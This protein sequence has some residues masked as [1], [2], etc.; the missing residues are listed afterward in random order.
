MLNA[1]NPLSIQQYPAIKYTGKPVTYDWSNVDQLLQ[2][3]LPNKA[4][5]EIKRIQERAISEKNVSE[6]WRTMQE[7]SVLADE[8]MLEEDSRQEI[9]WDYSERADDLPF[10]LN[11]ITHLYLRNWFNY[12][13]L[14]ENEESK[15]WKL[16]EK[17]VILTEENRADFVEYHDKASLNQAQ[18]L[19]E[20]DSEYTFY[21][22][23][24]DSE[25]ETDPRPELVKQFP[26]LFDYLALT[27]ISNHQSDF[28]SYY[29]NM[30]E[31]IP[32]KDS[33]SFAPTEALPT[34]SDYMRKD[35]WVFPL[36]H[37]I[38]MLHWTQNRLTP[39]SHALEYRIQ[40][41]SQYYQ[42]ENGENLAQ[43]AWKAAEERLLAK[44][45]SSA[46]IFTL[47]IAYE[48]MI[49]GKSYHWKNNSKPTD[50]LS[51]ALQKIDG[52]LKLFPDSEVADGLKD[53]KKSILDDE[54]AFNIKTDLSLNESQ[55]MGVD[56]RN[57]NH[58]TM[59]VFH[60][61]KDPEVYTQNYLKSLT[62]EKVYT[63]Q[64]TFDED[65]RMLP[66]SKDFLLPAFTSTGTYLVLIAPDVEKIEAVLLA[67]TLFKQTDFAYKVVQVTE[68]SVK[69]SNESSRNRIQV[70]NKQT[71]KPI[72]GAKVRYT[73]KVYGM[74]NEHTL[75]LK[76]TT[77]NSAGISEADFTS[78]F[79]YTVSYKG[80]SVS[81]RLYRYSYGQE[82]IKTKMMVYTDRS[83][84]RPGQ[85][86]NYKVIAYDDNDTRKGVVPDFQVRMVATDQNGQ[87]LASESK[88]T[89]QH[90]SIAGS[91]QL[92][93]SG[94]LPGAVYLTINE[95]GAYQYITVEEYKRPTFETVFD[96]FKTQYALGDS[97]T[98]SGKAIS[99]AGYP[100]TN[101]KVTVT[102]SEQRYLPWN[103]K[104]MLKEYDEQEFTT[105]TDE[106]GN[107]SVRF[108]TEKGDDIY[109]VNF[110][111]SA[112]VVNPTGETHEA[113]T[114]LYI[115]KNRFTISTDIQ[116][117]LLSSDENKAGIYV[118]NSEG[119]E[120]EEVQVNYTIEKEIHNAYYQKSAEESEFKAFTGNEL[121][122]A[123]P[124]LKYY[125]ADKTILRV[126]ITKGQ[127]KSGEQIDINK[128]VNSQPG[129]YRL[130]AEAT[131]ETG[132]KVSTSSVFTVINPKSKKNQHQAAF[133]AMTSN[134]S[135]QKGDKIAITI[136]SSF[137]D[138]MAYVE[139]VDKNGIV[140][141]KWV[142]VSQRKVLSIP[143]PAGAKD[144][145][146]I[147]VTANYKHQ[148]Y[149]QSFQINLPD[150][151]ANLI[152]K[153]ETKRDYL[154]PG[155]KETWSVTVTDEEKSAVPSELL[156][157]M[158]DA[159]LD[160]FTNHYWNAQL[161]YPEY[162][163]VNWSSRYEAPVLSENNQWTQYN[164]Y[165]YRW[166]YGGRY[167][168]SVMRGGTWKDT[169]MFESQ[170][171]S[172]SPP[173]PPVGGVFSM[174]ANV[175]TVSGNAEY[176][177]SDALTGKDAEGKREGSAPARIRSNFSETAF[178]FP[179]LVPESDG[180]YR[181][182]FTVPDAL[183]RWRFMSMAH[184]K[185]LQT[186]YSEELFMARKELM[187]T[188]NVPR[189]FRE[190]DVVEFAAKVSN[191]TDASVN[192]TTRLRFI[193][194]YTE[195]D[196][197]DQFGT[198]API[199][200]SINGKS[201]A[202]VSWKLT[203][204]KGTLNMVAY[205]IET[206]SSTYSDAEKRAVPVL[207]SRVLLTESKPFTKTSAGEST[208]TL[209]KVS[210]LGAGTEKV[211]L[212]LEI[213][214]QPLWT[215]LMSLPYLME[216]PHECAEQVFARYFANALA[217]KILQE[218][219]EFRQI[220]ELWKQD[221]PKAF[222]AQLEQNPELKAIILA[223]TPWVMDA[224]NEAQQRA[225]LT[226]LFDE[227]QLTAAI[228][229][230]L[231]KLE[232]LKTS[233]GTW[234]W[235]GNQN[236]NLYITQHIVSGFG[237][238]KELGI[239]EDASIVDAALAHLDTWYETLYKKLTPA[240]KKINAGLSD[241][242]IHWL[243]SRA[244][245]TDRK[246]EAVT[247]YR[248]C[249]EKNW[250]SYNL[251][252]QALMGID[253]VRSGNTAFA[254]KIKNSMMDRSTKKPDMG[255]YWNENTYG[256]N[257]NQA[258]IETQSIL[259]EFFVKLKG[260]SA[261]IDQMQLWLLQN[262]RSN[263]WE[264]TKSTTY[265]CYALLVNRSTVAR[266]INQVVKVRLADG[267]NL[268]VLKNASG[269]ERVWTGSEITPGKASVT[270]DASNNQPIFGAIHITYLSEQDIVEK[271]S[272]DIRLERHFYKETDN[273]LVEVKAG[274]TIEIG[275]KL[276]VKV[277]VTSN[278]SLE[279]VHIRAPHAYGFE[280][281][282]PLSGYRYGETGYY[283]VNRD[284]STELF[285]DFAKK[286]STT[287]S[288]EIFATGKGE[289]SVGPA[290][291]ECMYAPE[292]RANSTGLK[293]N[294]K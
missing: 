243:T 139:V 160:E 255:M 155:A 286:G 93:L 283:E 294:V 40:F 244:Y 261:E 100:I 271:S 122:K 67:D 265:A 52:S 95:G 74:N 71:G 107:F 8:G 250:K 186:G 276:T 112:V 279:F 65:K 239:D 247:Y 44:N 154:Q 182:S 75:L 170:A 287:F 58:A 24:F 281:V 6:F 110:S 205:V 165:G 4:I 29:Y 96:T 207:S 282:N 196:V 275:T 98:F 90:G 264:T 70:V 83:I 175:T 163:Y 145:F 117:Q 27:Y 101:A 260:L 249:M 1:Q 72:A 123:L 284:A 231:T 191:E 131:D 156:V 120:Q 43:K 161:T 135:A 237:Q 5:A 146:T 17:R 137:K 209:E 102:V 269:T 218:N 69:V 158:Y 225:H 292:F 138:L 115:G 23:R 2:D 257:W 199:T 35:N 152:V 178:F 241:L 125:E 31:M 124:F 203:V 233:E 190:G 278:R 33:L 39:Y 217:Q 215:T 213:Q 19:M 18:G 228:R 210:K 188:P 274:E 132:E 149:Q 185:T 118:Y 198:I 153:L 64:L 236:T 16:G 53:L 200:S 147:N 46:A 105:V 126:E 183:T 133:W 270:I 42:G 45:H 290:I 76:E 219:P 9:I 288:Y 251:Q 181:F 245:F 134:W 141:S 258:A 82:S 129:I 194:P 121:K 180:S 30:A 148:F 25:Y 41:V 85:T 256:Y 266:Q 97:I 103:Y 192:T 61:K 222:I 201:S 32:I 119:Y 242:T 172:A 208:F 51:K 204:P 179:Q 193:D 59:V 80:D 94:F 127:L 293:V 20:W 187:V 171:Y 238:L 77:T 272:G 13:E 54:L 221:D 28:A 173:P 202:D 63:Q 211:S 86:V 268:G 254:E 291:A 212:Q 195:K 128:A 91:F 14:S 229:Q 26:T 37:A 7:I 109:G 22:T 169:D 253:A 140:S 78:E 174:N 197:T 263:A 240:E 176:D 224:Q 111:V 108:K 285:A 87:Q 259:I 246:S 38:E 89:N 3:G 166:D 10:P 68:L 262:K 66:H 130:T 151:K 79:N 232:D 106:K 157:S 206:T 104:G 116:N 60:V 47:K 168:R 184:S 277:T 62:L 36:L 21:H 189:F 57:L 49:T 162:Y 150:P 11:N 50:E 99:Y 73:R 12:R 227:N 142:K 88:R 226:I 252:T 113:Y 230:A 235:F 48:L 159:S 289:L 15:S 223:E 114:N 56:Y 273:K 167:D 234:G 143:V 220:I 34:S 267:T 92:P 248:Q 84:Y 177:K 136:G 144:N 55:L 214:T 164:P 280:P 81:D 216:F